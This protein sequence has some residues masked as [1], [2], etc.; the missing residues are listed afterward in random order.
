MLESYWRNAMTP[1]EIK[2]ILESDEPSEEFVEWYNS[3]DT[4]LATRRR[5][6]WKIYQKGLRDTQR[7]AVKPVHF[8]DGLV[9]WDECSCKKNIV[10]W[11]KFCSECGARLNWSE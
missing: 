10:P 9:E 8:V 11:Y 1:D 3:S 5:H 4:Y 2:K 6:Q 7:E